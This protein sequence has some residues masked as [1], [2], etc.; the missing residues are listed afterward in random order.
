MRKFPASLQSLMANIS[1]TKFLLVLSLITLI[2]PA[3]ILQAQV[4]A[5]ASGDP[6][7][8]VPPPL[9]LDGTEKTPPALQAG[10]PSFEET[11]VELVNQERWANGQLPPLKRATELDSASATH[12]T[13]QGVRNFFGHCD[14]DTG[15]WPDDRMAAAGY[16]PSTWG[17][18][19]AAG[20]GTPESVMGAWMGSSGHRANILSAGF[21]EIGLGYHYDTPDAAG[22]RK[23]LNTD[24]ASDGPSTWP[25]FHYWT[26]NF[27]R[28]NGAYPVV[29]NR[30]AFQSPSRSVSLYVYGDGWAQ[31]MRIC[32]A[33]KIWS[34]WMP[35]SSDF[36]W[37]LEA[38]NGLKTV[39]AEVRS[40]DTAISASDTIWLE[41][42]SAVPL[43]AGTGSIFLPF[44][45]KPLV[46]GE[47]C[48]LP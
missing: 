36:A 42:P 43:A 15:T 37:T 16:Y 33:G 8:P 35:Y 4:P 10:A 11:L 48:P 12:S 1:R 34:D 7:G 23:D 38:G 3:I 22:V 24:C 17:E 41:E 25:Y 13:N 19:I 27:G 40:G 2:I 30:E 28:R 47:Y 39:H 45:A 20:F 31:E 32:N 9:S 44:A 18:N 6:P 29:I 14:L 21:W 26:Q 46:T 5:E